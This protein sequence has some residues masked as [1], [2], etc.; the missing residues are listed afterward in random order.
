LQPDPGF[1]RAANGKDGVCFQ[2]RNSATGEPDF[3]DGPDWLERLDRTIFLAEQ[4][5]IRLILPLV[6]YRDDFGGVNQYLQWFSVTGK[7]QFHRHPDVR[8]A[9]RNYVEHLTAAESARQS[10][11]RRKARFRWQ[12]EAMAGNSV[13]RRSCR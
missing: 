6:N 7:N 11:G 3:N 12:I 13:R 10:A 4:D 9:Y 5:G 2:Y 8:N 1:V